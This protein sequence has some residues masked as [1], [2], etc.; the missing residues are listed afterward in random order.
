[1]HRIG[2]ASLPVLS[3]LALSCLLDTLAGQTITLQNSSQQNVTALTFT[4]PANTS[5][6]VTAYQ[7]VLSVIPS[8]TAS[9]SISF[10]IAGQWLYAQ[11]ANTLPITLQNVPPSCPTQNP[12]CQQLTIAVDT[13][14][15]SPNTAYS[16]YF[17]VCYF[18][19]LNICAPGASGNQI[20]VT[21]NVTNSSSG[22]ISA[23][24]SAISCTAQSGASSASCNAS[25][26]EI[27]NSQGNLTYSLNAS[28]S[29]GGNWLLVNGALTASGTENSTQVPLSISST[30]LSTLTA[31]TYNGTIAATDTSNNKVTVAVTLTISQGTTLTAS[32][33]AVTFLFQTGQSAPAAQNLGVSTYSSSS[34]GFSISLS[35][36]VF[37]LTPSTLSGST[38][39]NSPYSITLNVTPQSLPVG[40][41]STSIV[42]SPLSGTAPPPIPVTLVV[43]NNPPLQLSTSSLTFTA[44]FAGPSPANQ[45]VNVTTSGSGASAAF[46]AA[47]DQSWL[48]VS[49]VSGTASGSAPATL[50]ASVNTGSLAI[51]SYTGHINVKPADNSYN[52]TILVSL[53]VSN[54]IQLTVGPGALLF[55][56]ETSKSAPPPQF[57]GV[58]SVGAPATFT[59]NVVS[60]CGDNSILVFPSTTTTPATLQVSV[61]PG[62]LPSA[63]AVCTGTIAVVPAGSTTPVN[64]P[65]TVVETTNSPTL[66]VQ[67]QQ[68]SS[69]VFGTFVMQQGGSAP[70]PQSLLL[71]TTDS[72][73][74]YSV[75]YT[76]DHGWL[77][78]TPQTNGNTPVNLAINVAPAALPPGTYIG[79]ITIASSSLPNNIGNSFTIPITLVVVPNVTVTASP[80]TMTFAFATGGT[81]P[82]AQTLT[83]T[84]SGGTASFTSSVSGSSSCSSMLALSPS[85]GPATGAIQVSIASTNSAV[86]T[87]NCQIN[88]TFVNAANAGSTIMVT[89]T[90]APPI[91][92]TIAPASL[93]FSYSTG[94]SQPAAQALT[95]SSVGGPVQ[96]TVATASTPSGWLSVDTTSGTT[97]GTG[98]TLTKAVNVSV[99]PQGLT[100]SSGGTAYNG[101]V[102]ITVTS[103]AGV[104]SP[105]TV[106]VT[107][108]V[109]Q[110]PNPQPTTVTSNA[111]N[112]A[113]PIAPGELITIKGALLGPTTAVLFGLNAQG[114]VNNTLAGVQV[115]FDGIPGTPIYVSAGQ[116]NV[117]A[118]W[119]IAGR[120]STNIVVSYNGSASPPLQARVADTAPAFYTLNSTGSGQAA[121]LNQNGTFNGPPGSNTVPASQNSVVALYATGCGQTNPPELT[122]TVSPL[123][124]LESVTSLVS[125]T[126]N[127]LF[128]RVLFTGAAPGLVTGVCQVNVQLP[129]GLPASNS[130][131]VVLTIGGVSSPLGP[132]IAVAAQ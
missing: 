28:T 41:Y 13:S 57:V 95:V 132:T 45:T 111:S 15:L 119:E 107:L 116:I 30:I 42:I 38:A 27:L 50:T 104:S 59:Y 14:G 58:Q 4:A 110:T 29:S 125:A 5:H 21:L 35:P 22:N 17:T 97:G 71:G 23:S 69:G 7:Q 20:Q 11:G 12:S 74:P 114:N 78:V 18:S 46:S 91:A 34:I 128:G 65:L 101:T 66:I 129:P 122:G 51:G 53:T 96:F 10:P 88:L 117:T 81:A 75:Q 82:A 103:P 47:S 112:V 131:S 25:T 26:L 32:P 105:I 44:A 123:N 8:V 92:V 52:E 61:V 73:V 6:N 2:T 121:A 1:M 113:G 48:S 72:A 56:Y 77:F 36:Q 16:S 40:T 68:P 124:Q 70:A 31:G 120:L 86:G 43:S 63:P 64:I 108:T 94:G 49:P 33:P 84:S 102:T 55:S 98:T 127:G 126:F 115:T 60:T 89:V 90:V 85:S 80:A 67:G 39:A 3:L 62:A 24:P 19:Q 106:N 9:I 100:G 83:L 37:W 87:Y 118:P 99:N 109:S 76:S 79:S 93:S 54:S 130:V